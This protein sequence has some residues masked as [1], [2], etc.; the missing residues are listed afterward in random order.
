MKLIV[1]VLLLPQLRNIIGSLVFC[2]YSSLQNKAQGMI[3]NK[4]H[5]TWTDSVGVENRYYCYRGPGFAS[6]PCWVSHFN[7]MCINSHRQIHIIK[8]KSKTTQIDS[9]QSSCIRYQVLTFNIFSG[10]RGG[11]SLMV[12]Q[13]IFTS[14][15]CHL[16]FIYI[17]SL[18][19]VISSSIHVCV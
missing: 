1:Q 15:N 11:S 9:T 2:V 19:L 3:K 13:S 14:L 10:G 4:Y 5:S 8:S 18:C 16:V 6:P 7:P 12:Q 17:S